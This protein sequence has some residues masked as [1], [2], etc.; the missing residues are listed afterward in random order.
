MQS[1]EESGEPLQEEA[2]V[3]GSRAH[4]TLAPPAGGGA[5]HLFGVIHGGNESAVAEFVM[6]ERPS[7]VVV[8]TSLN[9]AHGS[10]HGNTICRADCLTFAHA[11]APGSHEQRARMFAQYGVQLAD[12]AHPLGSH[13][14]HDLSQGSRALYNEQLVYVAAF[15]VGAD[16]VFGDRPKQITY[17]RML[18]LPSI[19]DLDQAYGAMSAS[20]Y[21][22]LARQQPPARRQ[23]G[24]TSA[25]EGA[26]LGERDAVMLSA[27]HQASLRCGEGGS[28]VGVVGASHLS[29]MQRL[30]DSGG[31]RQMVAGGLL[32]APRGPPVPESPDATGVRRALLDGVIRL[33]CRTDV[34]QD[35]RR[36]LGPVPPGSLEAYSLAHELY[37]TTR[38]LLA[39]LEREQLAEVCQGWRC[40]MWDVLAPV[41]AVR[42][43]N[44]GPGFDKELVLDLRTLNFEIA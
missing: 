22:D 40:D 13:L 44:G 17:S 31:W 18:W 35:V 33:S 32:E 11:S 3:D 5:I 26:L 24:S 34:Q 27:L 12:M 16:L 29:G 2:E 10:A 8:E 41:R 4:V 14:W 9:S 39:V 23:L 6:R 42:P 28:V 25:T 38:M 30:W 21:A 20:N 36:V 43:V 7:V 37:G 19:V 15:A 1:V